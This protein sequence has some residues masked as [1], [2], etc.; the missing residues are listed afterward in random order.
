MIF[1]QLFDSASCTYSYLIARRQGGEALIIDPVRDHVDEYLGLL[2]ALDLKL[3]KAIDTH[4]HADHVT[5]LGPLSDLTQCLTVMG[6]ETTAELV[7]VRV[8]DAERI[9]VDGIRLQAIHTPGHTADS[10][11]FLMDDRVFT[12][13]TLLI[14]GTGRTDLPGGDATQQYESLF[15]RLLRLDD[16]T[17]VFP[18]HDYKGRRSS[19]IGDEKVR[20]PRLQVGSVD[21]Y[22]ALMNS[23]NLPSPKMMDVAIPANLRLGL[24]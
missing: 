15:N 13:D 24:A 19:S 17:R 14:H 16:A 18:G 7:A 2:R 23:L 1:R 10:Y 6:A 11:C 4:L 12:G 9:D 5:A 20:N 8:G 22:V 21:Q 3:V